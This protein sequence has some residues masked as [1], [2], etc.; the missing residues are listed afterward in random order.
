M[1]DVERIFG[2]RPLTSRSEEIME[3]KEKN[4]EERN[5]DINADNENINSN[6]QYFVTDTQSVPSSND[7][8]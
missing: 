3:E 5:D 4:T 7:D 1:E 2:K 8:E 6:G